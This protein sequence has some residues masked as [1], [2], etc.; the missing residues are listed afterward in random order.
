M[1]PQSFRLVP[2]TDEERTPGGGEE[3]GDEDCIG[4]P[5]QQRGIHRSA[6]VCGLRQSILGA[7]E[8]ER[9]DSEMPTLRTAALIYWEGSL[10]VV[11]DERSQVGWSCAVTCVNA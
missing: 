2:T 8:L 1:E 10:L 3:H 5:Q 7:P 6:Q 11:N 9:R 4:E